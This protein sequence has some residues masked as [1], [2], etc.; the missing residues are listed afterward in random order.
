MLEYRVQGGACNTL[1]SVQPNPPL[2]ACV[3]WVSA[4]FFSEKKISE[5]LALIRRER[6]DF[7]LLLNGRFGYNRSLVSEFGITIMYSER[8]SDL[9]SPGIFLEI[10]GQGCRHLE[11]SW[12]EDYSWI[13]FFK[14]LRKPGLKRITRLDVAIDDFKGYL[15]IHQMYRKVR[16]GCMTSSAGLR[17][18]K[19]FDS[20]DIEN[21]EIT[22]ETLYLGKGD[23][24]FRFYDKKG[25]SL[26]RGKELKDNIEVWNR[27]EI[28]LRRERAEVAMNLIA[29]GGLTLGEFA[30]G[31]MARYISFRVRN[32]TDSN[33]RR[34]KVCAWWTKFLDK[35]EPLI[36]TLVHPENSLLK[37]QNWIMKSASATIAMLQELYGDDDMVMD[38]I[39][40][41]GREKMTKKHRKMIED[42]KY[43]LDYQQVMKDRAIEQLEEYLNKKNACTGD[44][45]NA[46][47]PD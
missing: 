45:T 44:Q 29:D 17:K 25:E 18:F 47:K 41:I 21:G 39:S 32:A 20:G 2:I 38:A 10:S 34:W 8:V 42:Y 14:E 7:E 28:Q 26:A 13:D 12:P 33:K 30:K 6:D 4:T 11:N 37:S 19:H 1:Q 16:D 9:S 15:G 35:V 31:V 27:Y 43:D 5:I 24:M 22:G 46:D 36:L 40:A 3:D 23:V